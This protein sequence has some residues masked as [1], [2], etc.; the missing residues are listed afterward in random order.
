MHHVVSCG[1]IMLSGLEGILL[2][3]MRGSAKSIHH[4]P[5][6]FV[7]GSRIKNLQIFGDRTIRGHWEYGGCKDLWRTCALSLYLS[8]YHKQ[9]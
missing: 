6:A 8:V 4:I 9:G 5:V 2:G 3:F 1:G 7:R